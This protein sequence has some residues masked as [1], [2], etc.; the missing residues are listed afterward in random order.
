M[1]KIKSNREIIEAAAKKFG[2]TVGCYDEKIELL[3]A[4]QLKKVIEKA[5]YGWG[6]VGL[7]LNGTRY[8]VEVFHVDNEIDFNVMTKREYVNQY[9]DNK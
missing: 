6:D 7:V 2:M 4:R 5:E 1:N 3:N 9:G 8:V